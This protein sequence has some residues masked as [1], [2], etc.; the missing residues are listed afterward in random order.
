MDVF[1]ELLLSRH[2]Y[3]DIAAMQGNV[4]V[5]RLYMRHL[6]LP[7]SSMD[8]VTGVGLPCF[9]PAKIIM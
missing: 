9:T 4:E 1:A 3:L 5:M 6:P 8:E 7:T 2:H